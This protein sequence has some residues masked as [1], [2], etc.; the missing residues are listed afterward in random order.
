[1]R[2]QSNWRRRTV[3]IIA[4][5]VVATFTILKVFSIFVSLRLDDKALAVGGHAVCGEEAHALLED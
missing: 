2:A 4:L 3:F 1:L 5:N